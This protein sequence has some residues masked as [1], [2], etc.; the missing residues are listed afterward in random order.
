M[1]QNYG[2]HCR[3]MVS[4]GSPIIVFSGAFSR[5]GHLGIFA[6]DVLR[7]GAVGMTLAVQRAMA[8]QRVLTLRLTLDVD[9]LLRGRFNADLR[10]DVACLAAVILSREDE[11]D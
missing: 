1:N 10:V 2:I 11:R 8:D 4:T 3:T 7:E 9:S 5:V 6:V